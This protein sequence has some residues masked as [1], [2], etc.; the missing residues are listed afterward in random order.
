MTIAL[1]AGDGRSWEPTKAT[2]RTDWPFSTVVEGP[3]VGA[4]LV[5]RCDGRIPVA[6]HLAFFR[7]SGTLPPDVPD[8]HFL[9]LVRVLISAGILGLDE[10]PLPPLPARPASLDTPRN[11]PYLGAPGTNPE[12]V[13]PMGGPGSPS[14]VPTAAR[15]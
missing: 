7:Q 9:H 14:V 6:E 15:T 1:R 2:L 4:A 13:A 11:G 3:P 10:F 12:G 5:S 8:D